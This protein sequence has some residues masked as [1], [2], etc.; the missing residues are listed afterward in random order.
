MAQINKY[1]FPKLS[2]AL[3]IEGPKWLGRDLLRKLLALLAVLTAEGNTL[4]LFSLP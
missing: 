1:A 3:F 4:G 2:K